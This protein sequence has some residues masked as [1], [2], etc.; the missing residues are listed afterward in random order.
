M[1]STVSQFVTPGILLVFT[2]A[3]GVW[4]S[5][6]GKPLNP[7]I[8]NLHKLIALAAVVFTTLQ[9]VK[10][11]N[12]S[13]TQAFPLALLI[14]AGVCVVALFLSGALMSAGKLSYDF[15]LI[16]HRAAPFGLVLSLAGVI[17]FLVGMG[18]HYAI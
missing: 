8:F 5:G 13:R 3:S 12:I 9:M 11:L 7:W 15:M 1:D 2:L 6:A 4:L 16:I 18:K 10:Q 17:Y 14:L